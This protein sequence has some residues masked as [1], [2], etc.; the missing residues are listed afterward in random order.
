[1]P[2]LHDVVDG[3]RERPGVLLGRRLTT[4]LLG[5]RHQRAADGRHLVLVAF[6]DVVDG[7][8]DSGEDRL[9]R[10][11]QFIFVSLPAIFTRSFDKDYNLANSCR[12]K[13]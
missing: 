13:R 6:V 10:L 5:D 11:K 1:M 8:P 2:R 7:V 9:K 12:S 3:A 4:V